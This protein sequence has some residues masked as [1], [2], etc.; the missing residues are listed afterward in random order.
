MR[1]EPA[2]RWNLRKE[3]VSELAAAGVRV[4]RCH[5]VAAESAAIDRVFAETGWRQAVVKPAVGASGYAVGPVRAIRLRRR[6]P[7]C[8]QACA[9]RACWCS[10]YEITRMPS[11][12][13]R[14]DCSLSLIVRPA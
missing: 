4:P 7:A 14:V 2:V 13:S 11:C 10:N 8:R 5:F 12:S 6:W 9:P 3:Y 1:A